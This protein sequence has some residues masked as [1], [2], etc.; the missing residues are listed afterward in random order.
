MPYRFLVPIGL[1]FPLH[2]NS[3]VCPLSP[4]VLSTPSTHPCGQL[5]AAFNDSTHS[6]WGTQTSGL[7]CPPVAILV[8]LEPC[9]CLWVLAPNLWTLDLF[10]L[11]L[12]PTGPRLSFPSQLEGSPDLYDTQFWPHLSALSILLGERKI[13]WPFA[14][15]SSIM[16]FQREKDLIT[17][18]WWKFHKN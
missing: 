18:T 11:L 14:S 5:R 7:H 8:S 10:I 13:T 2:W 12:W 16:I 17:E 1:S 9:L 6:C 3:L 15:Q 4:C